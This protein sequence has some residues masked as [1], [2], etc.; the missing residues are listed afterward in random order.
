MELYQ[1]FIVIISMV[2]IM[3]WCSMKNEEDRSSK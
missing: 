1:Y 2:S 3:L